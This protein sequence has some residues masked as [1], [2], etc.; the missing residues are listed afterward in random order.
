ME[1]LY[2]YKAIF[3]GDIL[4]HRPYIGLIYGR[5]LQFRFL[6]FPLI[7]C[8]PQLQSRSI[9]L[10]SLKILH[11]SIA[12]FVSMFAGKILTL[13]PGGK[14]SWIL[15]PSIPAAGNVRSCWVSPKIS[16]TS[17]SLKFQVACSKSDVLLCEIH[18]CQFSHPAPLNVPFV[19]D[20]TAPSSAAS[21]YPSLC[22]KRTSQ[23][24][25]L[26]QGRQGPTAPGPQGRVSREKKES[27]EVREEVHGNKIR[28]KREVSNLVFWLSEGL[29]GSQLG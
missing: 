10:Y 15:V 8:H 13:V 27:K 6:K 29:G 17:L 20:P 21:C 28:R 24:R 16:V 14:T 26:L 4:L 22:W 19:L 2:H 5:Y 12:G 7:H 23:A 25:P 18:S 1:V 3:C 11:P 9:Q